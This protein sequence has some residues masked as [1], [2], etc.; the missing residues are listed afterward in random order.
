MDA[1]Q[2]FKNGER[3]SD[4]NLPAIN[5]RCFYMPGMMLVP[6]VFIPDYRTCIKSY[7]KPCAQC[8][9]IRVPGSKGEP[10]L[11]NLIEVRFLNQSETDLVSPDFLV[12]VEFTAEAMKMFKF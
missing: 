7:I 9:V 6:D 4:N 10:K 12:S 2:I 8:D 3:F 1:I 5:T 11:K